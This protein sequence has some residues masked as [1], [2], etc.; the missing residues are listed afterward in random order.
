MLNTR[1]KE[2]RKATSGT[3][4][5]MKNLSLKRIKQAFPKHLIR[6]TREISQINIVMLSDGA[7]DS[8]PYI[9]V[10]HSRKLS[11]RQFSNTCI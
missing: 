6:I 7:V 8:R 2:I 1:D 11:H 10:I 4:S 9:Y 3:L 5:M